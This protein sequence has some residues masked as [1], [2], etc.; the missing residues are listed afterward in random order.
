MRAIVWAQDQVRV[1]RE[2]AEA[3]PMKAKDVIEGRTPPAGD[4][5][6]HVLNLDGG[7]R[8]VYSIESDQPMGPCR[9]LSISVDTPGSWPNP[10]AVLALGR[11]LGFRPN[12]ADGSFW[13]DEANEA[14]NWVQVIEPPTVH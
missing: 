14:V 3:H 1:L 8:L 6:G 7:V 11:E 9:H 4:I 10:T 13:L 12:L 2:Y 5:P